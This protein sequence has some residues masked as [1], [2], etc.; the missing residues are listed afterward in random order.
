[1]P[2]GPSQLVRDNLEKNKQ[3]AIA[4]VEVYNRPGPR[5]RTEHYVILIIIAWTALFHAI[6]YRRGVKPLFKRKGKGGKGTRYV[7]IDGEPKHWDL[8]ECLREFYGST[9]PPERRNLEF[10]IGLRNKIEHRHLPHLDATLYGE[11][12]ASLINLEALLLTEFGSKFAL[13]DQLGVALQFSQI[14][15]DE[16]AKVLKAAVKTAAAPVAT[17]I[18]TFRSNLPPTILESMK[19]SFSVFL[20]PRVANREK[21][22]DASVTFVRV[23][24]ASPEDLQRLLK[25]NILIRDKHIPIANL[26]LRKPGDVVARVAAKLP[27]EFNQ[28]HH[29]CAWRHFAVRPAKNAAKP[30]KTDSRYC[31]YDGAHDDYLYTDAWIDRL[32]NELSDPARFESITAQP[33]RT[34]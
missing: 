18:E 5:F 32:I 1:M 4:A 25:L 19:Y 2:K 15:P 24:E 22:A 8:T 28:H 34:R 23:D 20:V 33:A 3:S 16:K 21:A 31:I 17:Y 30:E 9:N 6:F 29:T 13:G 12:Q 7:K 10:L 27:H 11:C 26:D 14:V